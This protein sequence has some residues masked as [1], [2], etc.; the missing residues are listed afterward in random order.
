MTRG[1]K[2]GGG[3]GRGAGEEAGAGGRMAHLWLM[4]VGRISGSFSALHRH[5]LSPVTAML[6]VSLSKLQFSNDAYSLSW[7]GVGLWA[8]PTLALGH[9]QFSE[10]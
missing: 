5:T 9:T 1:I 2:G 3:E 8:V 4:A 6:H 10:H 7:V